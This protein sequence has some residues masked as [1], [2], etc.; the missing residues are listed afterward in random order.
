MEDLLE[1]IAL[2][3]QARHPLLLLVTH[4]EGRV[5][6]G[7]KNLAQDHGWELWRWRT[8]EGLRVGEAEPLPETTSAAA[9]LRSL[10]EVE[11]K[12]IFVF[13]DLP[14][15]LDQVEVRRLLR[16]LVE[17]LA[18]KGQ[19][20]VLVSNGISMP[21]ELEKDVLVLD[22]PLPSR[23]EIS[24]LLDIALGRAGVEL[25]EPELERFVRA[26]QGLTER[27]IQRAYAAILQSKGSFGESDL[28]R[29]AELKQQVI[30]RTRFLELYDTPPNMG[31]VGGLGN[32]KAW[33]TQRGQAFSDD[34][35]AFGLPEP[36]GVFL[37]GVQGCGKSLSAKAVASLFSV[38]LLRLDAGAVFR[39]GGREQESLGDVI[40]IAESMAP[41]VLWIDELEKAF[42]ASGDAGG[43]R[44]LGVFLTWLQE[45]QKP[46]FVVGT[47]NEV[48]AL[49]PELLRKGRFDEIFFVDLPD[50]HE[51][52]EILEIHL[53]ARG[54]EPLEIDL[55]QCAEETEKYSGAELEQVVVEALFHA[56]SDGS[57]ALKEQDL[58]RVIRDTVPLAVTMDD[59]LKELREWARPRARPATLDRRRIDFFDEFQEG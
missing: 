53:Q 51:R 34:A 11:A 42:L 57:R 4:E 39:G 15:H 52:L 30:R 33:L 48:R 14:A 38:P 41:V 40:R 17:P 7:L 10:L 24:V 43:T 36:R 49:P 32:L 31:E 20:V 28:V 58:L 3:I 8:T 56:Y 1:R 23:A 59:R 6:R 12:A 27:E 50:V 9:A 25:S 22:V 26:S 35:R 46:V 21:A 29:L 44:A 13:E 19:A 37:L 54:R 45:K 2:R 18:R 55:L 47:A 16:D 5:E